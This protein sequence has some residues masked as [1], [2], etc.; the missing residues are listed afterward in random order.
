MICVLADTF[1]RNTCMPTYLHNIQTSR[2][3]YI[4]AYLIKLFFVNSNIT[5]ILWFCTLCPLFD[6]KVSAFIAFPYIR[7]YAVL[8]DMSVVDGTTHNLTDY[9]PGTFI[10]RKFIISIVIA[11][12]VSVYKSNR[13]GTPCND[14]CFYGDYCLNVHLFSFW[15]RLI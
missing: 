3:I 7:P 9:A 12:L 6:N 2:N 13:I 10:V 15:S 1:T 8:I 14:V 11:N 4:Y 5:Q